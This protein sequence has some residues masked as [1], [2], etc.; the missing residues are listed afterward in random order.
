MAQDSRGV[1]LCAQFLGFCFFQYNLNST[2]SICNSEQTL[3]SRLFKEKN[4]GKSFCL[5]I[6][7]VATGFNLLRSS[8]QM[9]QNSWPIT[10]RCKAKLLRSMTPLICRLLFTSGRNKF[11]VL[12]FAYWLVFLLFL[13]LLTLKNL[14]EKKW[15]RIPWTSAVPLVDS[16]QEMS[17]KNTIYTTFTINQVNWTH[18]ITLKTKVKMM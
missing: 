15:I 7:K 18:P 11:I 6:C 14:S 16:N 13:Y 2:F 17:L 8:W 9:E 12:S 3:T 4:Q 10:L 1:F 5:F